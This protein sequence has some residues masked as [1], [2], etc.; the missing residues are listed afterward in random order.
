MILLCFSLYYY[1]LYSTDFLLFTFLNILIK[2]IYTK[3]FKNVK[4]SVPPVVGA[5]SKLQVVRASETGTSSQ[6]EPYLGVLPSESGP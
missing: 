6:Y 4:N 2:A 1:F 5:G 3:I